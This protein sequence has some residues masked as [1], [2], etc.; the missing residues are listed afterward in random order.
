MDAVSF[1]KD[2]KPIGESN[3]SVAVTHL[4]KH[5]EAR[6]KAYPTTVESDKIL[7]NDPRASPKQRVAAR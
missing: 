4:Q 3:E 6:L 5:L 1:E 2:A 7:E